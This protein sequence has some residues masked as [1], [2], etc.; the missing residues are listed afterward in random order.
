MP[1]TR[2]GRCVAAY[3]Y[4][5]AG[6]G[7]STTDLAWDGHGMIYENGDLLAE[8]DRFLDRSQRITAD[9]DLDSVFR[10]QLPG[11]LNTLASIHVDATMTKDGQLVSFHPDWAQ[12]P[13]SARKL[14]SAFN[15]QMLDSLA[16][17][18]LPLPNKKVEPGEV[19]P[20]EKKLTVPLDSS[21]LQSETVLFQALMKAR[22]CY[23]SN[24]ANEI[25]LAD[26]F[27]LPMRFILK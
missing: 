25:L 27:V 15:S 24:L 13:P 3:L 7:E 12:V 22:S 18:A 8:S 4:C 6:Y 11:L 10:K 2:S 20:I 17:L 16:I 26:V 23:R 21:A 9:I 1:I 14:I 19:W 5:A